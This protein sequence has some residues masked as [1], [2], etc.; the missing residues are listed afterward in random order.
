MGALEYVPSE[1]P[2]GTKAKQIDVRALVELA[3]E[4]LTRRNNLQGSF[5]SVDREESLRD[6]LRVGTS[7]GGAR[8]KAIIAWNPETKEIQDAVLKWKIFAKEAGVADDVA[9]SIAKA[10]RTDILK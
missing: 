1:G 9:K 5:A 8:A 10:Q 2:S 6:I 3:S 7:A 4:I